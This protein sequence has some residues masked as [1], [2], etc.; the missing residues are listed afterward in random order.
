MMWFSD[1]VALPI[2][3][4]KNAQTQKKMPKAGA[5]AHM[6]AKIRKSQK[7]RARKME[8]HNPEASGIRTRVQAKKIAET[9]EVII[10]WVFIFNNSLN[11]SRDKI[12]AQYNT[13]GKERK[14]NMDDLSDY[15]ASV[16]GPWRNDACL[17]YAYLAMKQAGLEDIKIRKVLDEMVQQFDFVSIDEAAAFGR[18]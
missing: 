3:T 4:E 11:Q 8:I 5:M 6:A 14:E 1:D 12:Q 7:G 10:F 13:A 9:I 16:N 18:S 15:M 17:G 2:S